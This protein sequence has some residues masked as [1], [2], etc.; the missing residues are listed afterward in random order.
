MGKSNHTKDSLKL[1][2]KTISECVSRIE[3]EPIRLFVAKALKE[4]PKYFWT[5]SSSSSGKHHPTDE[6]G[7]GGLVLHTVRVFNVAETMLNAF[8]GYKQTHSSSKHQP[9][10]FTYWEVGEVSVNSDV[11]RAGTILHD[12][13]RYGQKD[14]PEDRTI[15]NHAEIAGEV[16]SNMSEH[17][18]K[19]A[20]IIWC[21]ERHMGRWGQVLP[22]S[23]DEWIVHLAD[24]IATKYYPVK[25]YNA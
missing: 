5:S 24:T 11:V 23:P 2:S 10:L 25:V 8:E 20:M 7:E 6:H 9:G 21:V 17:F 16:L 14:K 1:P 3:D 22:N 12:L 13:Y 4:A 15:K 18:T 19:K